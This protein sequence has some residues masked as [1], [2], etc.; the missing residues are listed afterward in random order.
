MCTHVYGLAPMACPC[1]CPLS[2][3]PCLVSHTCPMGSVRRPCVFRLM[4]IAM[5]GGSN[6]PLPPDV[7]F[8]RVLVQKGGLCMCTRCGVLAHQ[9][10][11]PHLW[12]MAIGYVP[13][14]GV[15]TGDVL[16]GSS[17][18][19]GCVSRCHFGGSS[20]KINDA[21]SAGHRIRPAVPLRRVTGSFSSS[22]SIPASIE[23][24]TACRE[25]LGT[26][27]PAWSFNRQTHSSK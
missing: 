19:T 11:T 26:G 8:V 24:W 17:G 4:P 13:S 9:A 20:D 14:T 21:T 1:Q 25:M 18:R 16:H 3:S 15:T 7:P 27:C 10:H 6:P 23:R 2:L 22:L 12:Y 5:Q